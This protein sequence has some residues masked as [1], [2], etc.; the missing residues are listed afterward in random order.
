MVSERYSLRLEFIPGG[1]NKGSTWALARLRGVSAIGPSLMESGRPHLEAREACRY[2]SL[3]ARE[4]KHVP[5]IASTRI[6]KN[7]W[8]PESAA[9]VRGVTTEIR[10]CTFT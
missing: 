5:A 4:A 8:A 3:R 1:G 9:H 2:P 7:E 6:F 10:H